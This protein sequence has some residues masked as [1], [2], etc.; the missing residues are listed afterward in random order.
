LTAIDILFI[1][2]WELPRITKKSLPLAEI[3]PID[4]LPSYRQWELQM[5]SR[6]ETAVSLTTDIL[7]IARKYTHETFRKLGLSD[8]VGG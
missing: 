2:E 7:T 5:V 8:D 6:A 1:Y 4:G 3:Q